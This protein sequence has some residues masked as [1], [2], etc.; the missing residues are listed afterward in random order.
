[1][2]SDALEHGFQG[3]R[4]APALEAGLELGEILQSLGPVTR[5]A[6]G[7]QLAEPEGLAPS[8]RLA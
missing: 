3:G 8:L 4:V 2:R 6:V 1:M 7:L 5:E